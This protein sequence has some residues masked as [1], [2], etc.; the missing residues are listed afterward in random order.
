MDKYSPSVRKRMMQ[1]VKSKGTRLENSVAY[2]LRQNGIFYR[3]N[4]KT[5]NGKPDFSIK[6]YKIV[7]FIDSCFWHGCKKHCRMPKSNVNFWIKKINRNKERDKAIT[8][9]YKSLNWKILRV[10]EH[11]FVEKKDE[12]FN[13]IIL[14]FQEAIMGS[15]Y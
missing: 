8:K 15:N 12:T 10:W 11:D 3:R 14:A 9:Y 5:L 2:K 13:M 7:L 4:N 1:A 6:K